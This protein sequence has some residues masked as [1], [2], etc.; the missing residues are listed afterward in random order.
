MNKLTQ[1]RVLSIENK[2][3]GADFVKRAY[4]G[5][6]KLKTLGQYKGPHRAGFGLQATSALDSDHI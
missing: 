4:K 5:R 3:I 1:R 6:F 2:E